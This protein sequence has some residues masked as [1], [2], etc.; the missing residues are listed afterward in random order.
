MLRKRLSTFLWL[1]RSTKFCFY[2]ERFTCSQLPCCIPEAN[3]SVQDAPTNAT[4]VGVTWVKANYD[5]PKALVQTLQ[6]VHTVLSFVSPTADPTARIQIKLID[7]AVQAGVKR[8]APSEWA[9]WAY[10][11]LVIVLGH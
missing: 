5:D 8:F 9:S 4:A 7:A 6:G 10:S 2:L 11:K 3:S 1:L